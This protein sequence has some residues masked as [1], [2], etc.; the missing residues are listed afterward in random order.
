MLFIIRQNNTPRPLPT[1]GNQTKQRRV[2]KHGGGVYKGVEGLV[3]WGLICPKGCEVALKNFL[4][5]FSFGNIFLRNSSKN[6]ELPSIPP[7]FQ[8][9]ILGSK[10]QPSY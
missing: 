5:F 3:S 2:G 6:I 9:L 4:Y 10:E 7:Y 1:N 8:I